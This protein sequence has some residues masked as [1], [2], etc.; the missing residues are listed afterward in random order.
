[1]VNQMDGHLDPNVGAEGYRCT[2]R[3]EAT[4][5]YADHLL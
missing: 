1:M 5:L 2:V 4:D 3:A